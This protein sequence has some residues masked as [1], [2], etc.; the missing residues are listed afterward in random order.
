MR[1]IYQTCSVFRETRRLP[2]G[3]DLNFV[4]DWLRSNDVIHAMDD[5]INQET[6]FRLR[7]RLL[8]QRWRLLRAEVL[9]M[10]QPGHVQPRFDQD[11]GII[12][13]R[14]D[15]IIVSCSKLARWFKLDLQSQT[16]MVST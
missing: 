5:E 14:R 11:E 4:L 16:A 1:I 6:E 3:S 8:V 15:N 13:E 7:V 10:S 2:A 9:G 12:Q